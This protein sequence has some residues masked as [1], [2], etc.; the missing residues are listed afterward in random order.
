[1]E[2]KWGGNDLFLA[3]RH[4]ANRDKELSASISNF[5][6]S[7]MSLGFFKIC[8]ISNRLHD[9][10]SFGRYGDKLLWQPFFPRYRENL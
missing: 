6:T 3:S 9:A 7:M 8:F 4:G 2:T 10:V 5:G 1:M